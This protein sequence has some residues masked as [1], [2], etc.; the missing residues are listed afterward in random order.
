MRTLNDLIHESVFFLIMINYL[1]F[2]YC[3]LE[4]NLDGSV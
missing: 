1:I 4:R 2:A 3:K